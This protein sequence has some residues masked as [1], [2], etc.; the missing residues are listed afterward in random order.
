[1]NRH[2]MKNTIKLPTALQ[3]APLAS[4]NSFMD[5]HAGIITLPG[6]G[7]R[8]WPE[9]QGYGTS[10]PQIQQLQIDHVISEGLEQGL[11]HHARTIENLDLGALSIRASR[12][13][14]HQGGEAKTGKTRK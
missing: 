9:G 4:L 10:Q 2:A 7:R 13:T 6:I 12:L 8:G 1:M 3:L 11:D 14:V 5:G